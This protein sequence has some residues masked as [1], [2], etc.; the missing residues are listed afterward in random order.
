MYVFGIWIYYGGIY[1]MDYFCVDCPTV[2]SSEAHVTNRP[3]RCNSCTFK[4]ERERK[5]RAKRAAK[6]RR[7]ARRPAPVVPERLP[8]SVTKRRYEKIQDFVNSTKSGKSCLDCGRSFPSYCLDYHHRNPMEK[9][10]SVSH[11]GSIMK[12]RIEIE[13]C[14]LVCACCHRIRHFTSKSIPTP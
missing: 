11:A 1:S 13:K 4:K 3:I 14:D 10:L 6:M 5:K 2:L 8:G 7:R 12:A 9:D